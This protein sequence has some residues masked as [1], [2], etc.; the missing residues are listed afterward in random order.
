MLEKADKKL[1][2]L[3]D[4]LKTTEQAYKDAEKALNDKKE[5]KK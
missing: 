4:K 5:G 3:S 2:M 1:D